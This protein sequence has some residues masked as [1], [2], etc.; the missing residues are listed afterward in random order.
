MLDARRWLLASG[1]KGIRC[2]VWG[3]RYKD[4]AQGTRRTAQGARLTAQGKRK[5]YGVSRFGISECGFGIFE[6]IIS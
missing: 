3:V 1:E 5:R 6:R 2:K 4:R